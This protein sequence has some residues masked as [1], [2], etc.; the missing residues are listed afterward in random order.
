[1]LTMGANVYS[2]MTDTHLTNTVH[3]HNTAYT[4]SGACLELDDDYLGTYIKVWATTDQ[5][6][7]FSS[8]N[9][10]TV[11]FAFAGTSGDVIIGVPRKSGQMVFM[12]DSVPPDGDGNV[13]LNEI[14]YDND[15]AHG[16]AVGVSG[17][18][19]HIVLDPCCPQP[20]YWVSFPQAEN[21]KIFTISST[22]AIAAMTL[23]EPNGYAVGGGSLISMAA[24]GARS[25]IFVREIN[26][27]IIVSK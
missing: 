22:Q 9:N 1:M 25:W 19:R 14:R 10:Y 5:L 23:Y 27:W 7:L 18:E 24:D 17:R 13:H 3:I 12:V 20:T 26:K 11:S 2:Q 16:H 6:N 8:D 4:A 15:T 21:E